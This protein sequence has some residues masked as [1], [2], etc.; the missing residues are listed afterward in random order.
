MRVAEIMNK[1]VEFVTTETPVIDVSSLIFG[2]S[3][4]GVPVVENKKLVGFITERDILQKFFP[5]VSEYVEDP[6]REGNF[7]TMEEKVDEIF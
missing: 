2:R 1:Q 3:I 4:N 6:F 5:K 7:E